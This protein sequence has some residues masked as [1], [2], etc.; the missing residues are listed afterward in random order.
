MCPCSK[1]VRTSAALAMSPI[2]LGLANNLGAA[3]A[4]VR[5]FE[6]VIEAHTRARIL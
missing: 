3:L 4:K 1:W 2:L 5:R 6:E